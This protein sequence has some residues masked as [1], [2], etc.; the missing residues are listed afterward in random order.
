[1]TKEELK[2]ISY[3]NRKLERLKG[4]YSALKYKSLVKGQE[5]TGMP[6]TPGV[7]D[8]VGDY[9]V[10][11]A[12]LRNE[13]ARLELEND[14][15][16]KRARRFIAE[17]PDYTIQAI[18]ELK[19]INNLYSHEVACCLGNKDIKGEKDIDRILTIFFFEQLLYM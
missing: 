18:L 10:S 17:I 4:K 5:I 7:K 1:M 8:D 2:Q 6:H 3:N 12:D 13:I 9:A 16:I 19:Y 15:L 14:M 11:L